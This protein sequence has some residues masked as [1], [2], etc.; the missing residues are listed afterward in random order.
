MTME[1][2]IPCWRADVA[3]VAEE[4]TPWD[5]LALVNH[6]FWHISQAGFP[7]IISLF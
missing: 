7:G 5:S 6:A 4:K 2:H 1:I 3:K